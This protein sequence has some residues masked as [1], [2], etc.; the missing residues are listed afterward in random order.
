MKLDKLSPEQE[1]KLEYIKNKWINHYLNS[2]YETN[3]EV[4]RPLIDDIYNKIGLKPPLIFI[5]DGYYTQ[6]LMINYII[7]FLKCGPVRNQVWNQV[8]NQVRNQVW[9]QVRNQVRN[10]V[11][12]QVENQVRNQVWNQVRNQVGNQV[13]NQVENQVGNQVENQ[14]GNQVRNQVWN[15]VRNQVGNQVENQVGNQ[16][17]NQVWN[18]VGNQVWNQVRNQVWDQKLEF[19]EQWFGAWN[20][21]WLSFYDFFDGIGIIKNDEFTKYMDLQKQGFSIVMFEL[22]V[23]VCKMPVKTLTDDSNRLHSVSEASVQ[24]RDNINQYFIHGVPFEYDLWQKVTKR[25]LIPKEVME[26]KNIEQRRVTINHYGWDEIFDYFDKKLI[27]KSKRSSKAE[28]YRVN[29]LAEN[30]EINIVKYEDPSTGRMYVS[31]VP[32]VDD[33]GKEITTADHAMA[34]KSY[35]TLEEYK[36]LKVEA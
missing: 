22:F 16:V 34:W 35:L 23:V 3:H 21:G 27:N 5:A 7:S 9:N 18:Q 29:G 24:W 28:L 31:Q 26:M 20:A 14:V 30:I 19:F 32:D 6:K 13:W 11:G 2:G 8:W 1:L 25:E 36:S 10:Q 17:R 4:L 12:N 15:Q 33:F